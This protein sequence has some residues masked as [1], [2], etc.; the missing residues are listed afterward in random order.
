MPATSAREPAWL[1]N[2]AVVAALR[3]DNERLQ[4][5]NERMQEKARSD[6]SRA[7]DLAAENAEL[8][9]ALARHEDDVLSTAWRAE[10]ERRQRA[11]WGVRRA[12]E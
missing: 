12:Q 11:A 2:P 4:Q 8:Q 5:L 3:A 6:A 7:A 9:A 1:V 10:H